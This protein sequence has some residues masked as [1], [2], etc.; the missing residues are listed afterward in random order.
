M[1]ARIPAAGRMGRDAPRAIG[2][3]QAPGGAW[4]R[5]HQACFTS[6]TS[7]VSDALASPKSIEVLGL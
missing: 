3:R 2:G 6:V 4:R 1:A 7:F 5:R